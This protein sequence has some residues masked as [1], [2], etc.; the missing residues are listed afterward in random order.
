MNSSI[1]EANRYLANAKELLEEKAKRENGFYRDKKY[2]RLAGHA[3]IRQKLIP[4][5]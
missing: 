1:K 5:R 2:I 4:N 3:A